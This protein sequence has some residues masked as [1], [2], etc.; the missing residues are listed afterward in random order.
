M[1]KNVH[2]KE[3]QRKNQKKIINIIIAI[4]IFFVCNALY[5][6]IF[7][8]NSLY[9]NKGVESYLEKNTS[10]YLSNNNSEFSIYNKII[11]LMFY[12]K[13]NSMEYAKSNVYYEVVDEQE[14]ERNSKVSSNVEEI[15][16]K[17]KIKI[18]TYNYSFAYKNA[19]NKTNKYIEKNK[20][21]TNKEKQIYFAEQLNNEIN[22]VIN[23]NDMHIEYI[24]RERKSEESINGPDTFTSTFY[25]VTLLPEQ[26]NNDD[27]ANAVFGGLVEEMDRT[28]L[29]EGV[30]LEETMELMGIE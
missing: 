7:D 13:D 20:K 26:Y 10:N 15:Y 24:Y 14:L 30:D 17:L 3:V 4:V 2:I 22:G 8:P 6:F 23:N 25:Y 27:L 11:K 1:D 16:I 19:V 18:S 21:I 12:D 5:Y 28:K 29:P 9:P